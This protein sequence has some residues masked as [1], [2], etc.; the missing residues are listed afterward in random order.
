MNNLSF[1]SL[2][3]LG[4]RVHTGFEIYMT[5]V[6]L[7]VGCVLS[8]KSSLFFDAL[9]ASHGDN[10]SNQA[11]F[12][13][14]TKTS[15]ASSDGLTTGERPSSNYRVSI[16]ALRAGARHSSS[17]A[18]KGQAQLQHCVQGPGTAPILIS[19]RYVRDRHCQGNRFKLHKFKELKD[20]RLHD[21]DLD[22][23]FNRSNFCVFFWSMEPV[24]VSRF[25]LV[26]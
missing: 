19:V 20:C 25:E 18:C 1:Y 21:I 14:I 10:S 24:P 17:I 15:L 2:A 26:L 23:H 3:T 12:K 16:T 4:N 9:C 13:Q 5:A 6:T 7:L 22:S 11:L 8:S